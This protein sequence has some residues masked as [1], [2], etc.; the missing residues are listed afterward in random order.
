MRGVS[1]AHYLERNRPILVKNILELALTTE[2]KKHGEALARGFVHVVTRAKSRKK[3]RVGSNEVRT[4]P[5]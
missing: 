5:P 3:S 1:K 2:E 4:V